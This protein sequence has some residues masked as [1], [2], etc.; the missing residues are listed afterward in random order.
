MPGGTQRGGDGLIALT[1]AGALDDGGFHLAAPRQLGERA[2]RDRQRDLA[3]RAA[4]PDEAQGERVPDGA[5]NHPL[6]DEAAQERLLARRGEG[7]LVPQGRQALADLG[8]RGVEIRADVERDDAAFV[9]RRVGERGFGLAQIAQRLLPAPLEFGGDETVVRIDLIELPFGQR[10]PVAQPLNL[11]RLSLQ[12]G[13]VRLAPERH[14]PR[15]GIQFGGGEGLEEGRHGLGIDRSGRDGL[16]HRH[17]VLL[18]KIVADVAGPV[19]VLDHHLVT[20]RA[21]VNHPVQQRGALPRHAARLVPV[22]L[23]VIVAQHGVDLLERRPADIGGVLVLHDDPPLLA[24]EPLLRSP[25]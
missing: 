9:L 4:A 5:V 10:R 3:R 14:C 19:P 13:R 7:R 17:A 21:A 1:R 20:A 6:I 18:T 23:G 25:D 22:V 12:R 2:Y 11:L 8:Q 16:A 24:R 15:V